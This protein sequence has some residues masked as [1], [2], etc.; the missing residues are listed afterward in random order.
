MKNEKG[1]IRVLWFSPV[2]SMFD[3]K[4][5]GTWVAALEDAVST[6]R[7]D[8]ELGIA[9]EYEN[10]AIKTKNAFFDQIN[11]EA[12]FHHDS[13]FHFINVHIVW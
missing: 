3:E 13:P 6:F 5:R 10:K 2:P 1:K 12:S 11:S 8:I 7:T 9:F 4:K